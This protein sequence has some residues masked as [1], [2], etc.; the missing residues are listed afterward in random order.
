MALD[1]L[2]QA[3]A[4]HGEAEVRQVLDAARARAA[5]IRAAADARTEQRCADALAA[6]EAELRLA[7][8]AKRDQALRKARVEVLF[9]RARYLDKV[10]AEVERGLPGLLDRPGAE[11]VLGRLTAEGLDCF[12]RGAARIRCRAGLAARLSSRP[13]PVPV[14]VDDT[15]PEGVIVESLDGTARVDNTLQARLRRQRRALSITLLAALP[16]TA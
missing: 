1:T 4:E 14:V 9:K 2:L 5:E 3:I 16:E 12:P 7:Y 6:R 11:D 8:D 10:F 13:D 15:V